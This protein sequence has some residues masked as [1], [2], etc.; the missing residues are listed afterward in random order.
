MDTRAVDYP[1]PEPITSLSPAFDRCE[2]MKLHVRQL[3]RSGDTAGLE[4]VAA[5]LRNSK[6]SLDGGTWFLTHFY[7]NAA[8]VTDDEPAASEAMEFYESWAKKSPQSITAQVCLS[9]AL[10]SYAWNARGGGYA[11]TVT[12]EGWRVMGERLDRAWQILENAGKLDEQCP[13]WFEVAQRVALGQSWERADYFEM[14]DEAIRR[15]PTYGAYYTKACYW[16]L[17]RWH[18]E[19]GDFEKWIAV[20][21]DSYPENLR[22]RQYARLVWMADLMPVKGE[23]FFRRGRLDW[24]RAKRGF[25]QWLAEDPHNLNIRFEY[26]GLALLANDR[27]TAREQFEITGGIYYPGMWKNEE[28]FEQARRFAYEGGPNP[29][30]QKEGTASGRTSIPAQTLATVERVLNTFTGLIGGTLAGLFLLWLAI[31]R[32]HIAAGFVALGASM[33]LGAFFGTLSSLIPAGLLYFI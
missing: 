18:G 23:L 21:A 9:D 33:L 13:G 15:E 10:V 24:P 32:R 17:P 19:P 26:T 12:S 30:S 16:L 3:R 20:Q 2:A 4:A 14:V 6:E 7:R 28:Q 25:E 1:P 22:D 5:E 27:E 11:N 29:L 31:Q 8:Y